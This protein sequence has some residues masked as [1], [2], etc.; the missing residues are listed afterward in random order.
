ML[1]GYATHRDG[2]LTEITRVKISYNC[3]QGLAEF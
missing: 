2:S 3:P 1:V